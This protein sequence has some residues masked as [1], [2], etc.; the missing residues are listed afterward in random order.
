MQPVTFHV[1]ESTEE[2]ENKVIAH[3]LTID[4]LEEGLRDRSINLTK[5][6]VV[7]IWDDSANELEPS[8]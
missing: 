1:Y 6:E 4:E 2:E 5:H 7:P 8:Y 3:N